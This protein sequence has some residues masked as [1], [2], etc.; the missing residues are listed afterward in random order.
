MRRAKSIHKNE[1]HN[2]TCSH[3]VC[4]GV[5]S[6]WWHSLWTAWQLFAW[7]LSH[8]KYAQNDFC[9][10][11]VKRASF[12]WNALARKEWQNWFVDLA[13][14]SASWEQCHGVLKLWWRISMDIRDI[15]ISKNSETKS[16]DWSWSVTWKH[17]KVE[18]K[19]NWWQRRHRILRPEELVGLLQGTWLS[20]GS[21]SETRVVVLVVVLGQSLSVPL[22]SK[23]FDLPM[24]KAFVKIKLDRLGT[25]CDPRFLEVCDHVN[26]SHLFCQQWG[27]ETECFT[28]HIQRG[29]P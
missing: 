4:L 18:K 9:D 21:I 23:P 26:L 25:A 5:N 28:T 17:R 15:R 29:P 7:H 27:V 22:N 10:W 2:A 6:A 14:K 3:L 8:V 20:I 13:S 19:K 1:C 24:A 11:W 12:C 16:M